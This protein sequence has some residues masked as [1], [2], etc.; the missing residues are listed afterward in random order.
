MADQ[1]KNITDKA[2][3]AVGSMSMVARKFNLKSVQS[4]ANWI[5]NNQVPSNRVIK[6]CYLGNW[7]VTSH[8]LNTDLYPNP[9]DVIPADKRNTI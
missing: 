6:L 2:V 3:K 4:V 9:T 1:Y 5:I 8:E 7:K